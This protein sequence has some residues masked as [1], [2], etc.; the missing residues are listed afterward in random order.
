MQ[1]NLVPYQ[2]LLPRKFWEQVES[3]KELNQKIE[4]YFSTCYPNYV[5]KKIVKSGAS[6]MA[7]C[8]RR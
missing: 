6:Y 8:E 7:V 2:V 1:I 5:I 3:E 4:Q